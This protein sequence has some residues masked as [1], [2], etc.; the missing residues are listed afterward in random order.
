MDHPTVHHPGGRRPFGEWLDRLPL[1]AQAR[2][3]ARIARFESGNPGDRRALGVGSER[4]GWLSGLDTASILANMDRRS[5]CCSLVEAKARNRM[6]FGGPRVI[7]LD[8]WGTG[9]ARRSE[10]WN[11]D[12]A[13]RLGNR[14][15]ARA[16]L[17]AAI[18][19]GLTVQQA[20]AKVIRAIGI[21]EFAAQVGMPRP[22]V[23]RAIHSR[24]NPTQKTL[25]RLLAP[26]RLQLSL[27][28]IAASRR[29]RAA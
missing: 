11:I 9:M 21:T 7:G 20:L 25:N 17:L 4:L 1:Q 16:F 12:L 18:D 19:E 3:A 22:N 26:F 28:L 10:D 23:Q 13:K 6:T 8:T 15:F 5:F 29:S 2:V 14:A 27:A 24:H